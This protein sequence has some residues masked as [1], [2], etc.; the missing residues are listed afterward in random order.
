MSANHLIIL[1]VFRIFFENLTTT[2]AQIEIYLNDNPVNRNI[3][4]KLRELGDFI[5]H[6]RGV[7]LGKV[8]ARPPKRTRKKTG[9][10]QTT[11]APA[12]S[13]VVTLYNDLVK[14]S[15]AAAY[16]LSLGISMDQLDHD[17]TQA[18]AV[19]STVPLE[20]HLRSDNRCFMRMLTVGGL[21]WN[22]NSQAKSRDWGQVGLAA[23]LE[24]LLVA[25]YREDLLKSC[26]GAA[27]MR[28]DLS[29]YFLSISRSSVPKETK[30][31]TLQ[32]EM[33]QGKFRKAASQKDWF[34]ADM[35]VVDED[36]CDM[37]EYS[38]KALL[39]KLVQTQDKEKKRQADP[40]VKLADT[41]KKSPYILS[42]Q[43]GVAPGTIETSTYYLM[44]E[45]FGVSSSCPIL[46]IIIS[47]AANA[48]RSLPSRPLPR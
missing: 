42:S 21:Q 33:R 17:L 13:N 38:S 36:A 14:E 32:S 5:V 28:K 40:L 34:F 46:P 7:R 12:E 8:S 44:Q 45:M 18:V 24:S 29:A 16:V 1:E 39:S 15:D 47:S 25:K 9:D 35:I 41:W 11:P 48:K 10:A 22:V 4:F 43:K 26:Q 37:T 23:I 30:T 20:Q 6:L 3:S 19:M 27:V 2:I 31:V